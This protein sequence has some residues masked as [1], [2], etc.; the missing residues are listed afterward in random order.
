MQGKSSRI[1]LVSSKLKFD[2][3]VFNYF[4]DQRGGGRGEFKAVFIEHCP[5]LSSWC[6]LSHVVISNAGLQALGSYAN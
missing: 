6:W 1:N 2:S 3:N 5:S 4:R